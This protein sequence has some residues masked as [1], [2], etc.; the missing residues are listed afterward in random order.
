MK[1]PIIKVYVAILLAVLATSFQAAGQ[2]YTNQNK[3]WV[4]ADSIGL[5][6]N[7]GAPTVFVS[8]ATFG[9]GS[10]TVSDAFGN[11]LFYTNGKSVWDRGGALMPSGASLVPFNTISTS[12]GAL[13]VPVI[14]YSNKYYVFSLQMDQDADAVRSRLAYSIVDMSLNYGYGDV[15]VATKGTVIDSFMSEKMIAVKGSNCNIWLLAHRRDTTTFLAYEITCAG[16]N[17][18]PVESTIGAYPKYGGYGVM[19]ASPNGRKIACMSYLAFDTTHRTELYD[20]DPTSGI[21]SSYKLLNNHRASYGAEFSPDNSKLYTCDM[22]TT[23]RQYDLS[24]PSLPA[25]IASE[26]LLASYV[27]LISDL[28]LG[29][30]S[31]IYTRCMSGGGYLD[32]IDAPNLPGSAC[33][34]TSKAVN[35]LSNNYTLGL[36][37]VNIVDS[38]AISSANG[39]FLFCLGTS[40][41]ISSGFSGGVWSS[42]N[43]SVAT[44]SASGIVSGISVGTAIIS[45]TAGCCPS[46]IVVT[47]SVPPAPINGVYS[48][49]EGQTVTLTNSI[50][51]GIWTSNNNSIATVEAT[52]GVVHGV[53]GDTTTIR[54]SIGSCTV[55]VVL[56]VHPTPVPIAGP[57]TVCVGGAVTW[58]SSSG[59]TWYSTNTVVALV[60]SAA[61]I[62]TGVS[63][64]SSMITYKL[65]HGCYTARKIYAINCPTIVQSVQDLPEDI[66]LYPNPVAEMGKVNIEIPEDNE[67]EVT[68][69][70]LLGR[71][72]KTVRAI[73]RGGRVQV[74][75]SD[76]VPGNYV[77]RIESGGRV[78]RQKVVVASK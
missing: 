30:D 28:K 8:N 15:V 40:I 74:D 11:L 53:L 45:Y 75:V 21:V 14:G 64:G 60:D 66:R 51:G 25:I 7:S 63:L 41:T 1:H 62:I 27:G 3:V 56:T 57:P 17:L 39:S 52:N 48:V 37:N 71:S 55:S 26:Y 68:I 29:P 76:V 72:I 20:F 2:Y 24:L 31:K 65:D 54:Y 33:G 78:Y 35:L 61:G 6:F 19:K 42:S 18:T 16:I 38:N 49:C 59:G 22:L 10:A 12:Q 32:R 4:F 9:E 69:T 34:Y 44:V 58:F 73:P 67:I 5:D 50:P 43:P 23:I 77:V 70:D 46:S 13:I 36:P 47:V